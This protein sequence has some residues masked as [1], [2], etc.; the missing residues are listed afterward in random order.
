MS[1][2]AC[3]QP[4]PPVERRRTGARRA[5]VDRHRLVADAGIARLAPLRARRADGGAVG[6]SA[7]PGRRFAARRPSASPISASARRIRAG[8]TG[9]RCAASRSSS[10]RIRSWPDNVRV[11]IRDTALAGG[12]AARGGAAPDAARVRRADARHRSTPCPYLETKDP[13]RFAGSRQALRDWLRRLRERV[14]AGGRWSPTAATRWSTPRRTSTRFVVEGVFAIYDSGRRRLSARR[15]KP[16]ATGSWRAIARALA[17]APR[18]VFTIEYA[19]VGDVAL[20]QLGVRGVGS[21]HG[22]R[23]Y[24]GVR[25]LNTAAVSR[26]GA[27]PVSDFPCIFQLFLNI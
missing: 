10:S 4:R 11:D 13:A 2:V 12:P 9:R 27:R 22:F 17:V 8:R 14:P 6:R 16:S 26:L 15:P 7:H 19:D 1:I 25:D 3:T 21:E 20:S 18:P 24:V 23:P 5:L